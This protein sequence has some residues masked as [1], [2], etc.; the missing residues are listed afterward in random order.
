MKL[1]QKVFANEIRMAT[2]LNN[3][4]FTISDPCSVYRLNHHDS[5][6][7]VIH[8]MQHYL[9]RWDEGVSSDTIIPT[10]NWNW[11]LVDLNYFSLKLSLLHAYSV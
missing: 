11:N 9:N 6:I 1:L 8:S 5:G 2:P 7:F 3:P 10:L 4:S